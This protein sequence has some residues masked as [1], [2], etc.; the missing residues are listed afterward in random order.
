LVDAVNLVH[1]AFILFEELQVV[2]TVLVVQTQYY[3][4]GN[5]F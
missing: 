1:L 2:A 3:I 5:I 4:T